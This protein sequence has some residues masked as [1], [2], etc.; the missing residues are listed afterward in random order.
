MSVEQAIETNDSSLESPKVTLSSTK[1]GDEV[2]EIE[3]EV[4]VE[5]LETEAEETE[6]IEAAAEVVEEDADELDIIVEG[7]AEPTSTPARKSRY[8]KRVDKLN[9]KI[10]VAN[11][12]VEATRL[13]N[14]S[15]REQ[16][17]LLRMKEEVVPAPTRPRASDFDDD[18][19]FDKALDTYTDHRAREAAGSMLREQLNEASTQTTQQKVEDQLATDIEAHYERA[20]ALKVKNYTDVEDKAIEIFGND[21]SKAII[22]NTAQS[23]LLMYH[24]GLPRNAGKAEEFA[25]KLKRNPVKGLLEIGGYANKLVVKPKH[26]SAPDPESRVAPG[27]ATAGDRGPKGAKFW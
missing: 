15:L 22:A 27:T 11:E 3:T 23:A 19:T 6:A 16:N 21:A 26:S 8:A 17:K 7:E 20:D 9:G 25:A 5:V 18:E 1:E 10:E 13:E 4:E 12:E 14:E 24:F 2:A